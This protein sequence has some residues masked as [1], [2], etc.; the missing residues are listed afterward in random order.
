MATFFYSKGV[1]TESW[2]G[3]PGVGGLRRWTCSGI[4]LDDLATRQHLERYMIRRAKFVP[5]QHS[6]KL[7]VE[8][9]DG[10]GSIVVDSINVKDGSI[11]TGNIGNDIIVK[12]CVKLGPPA[13]QN[14]ASQQI[15]GVFAGKRLLTYQI[16]FQQL[17]D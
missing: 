13:Y 11:R 7:Y 16:A 10:G 6:S 8:R 5:I 15:V 14:Y 9:H 1:L 4:C 2:S 17:S 3:T 12:N